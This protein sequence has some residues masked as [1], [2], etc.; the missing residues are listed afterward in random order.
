M[1][2][3][4]TVCDSARGGAPARSCAD[5]AEQLRT[6]LASARSADGRAR[7]DGR[8][9]AG[10]RELDALKAASDTAFALQVRGAARATSRMDATAS[11]PY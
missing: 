11:G 1:S 6:E 4:T 10:L 8:H 2:P 7:S 5:D 3:L 9:E